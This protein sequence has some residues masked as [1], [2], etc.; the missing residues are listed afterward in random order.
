VAIKK[1]KKNGGGNKD[2][3][4]E[5]TLL[6]ELTRQTYSWLDLANIPKFVV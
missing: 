1:Y 5:G 3:F 2:C 4:D 6:K